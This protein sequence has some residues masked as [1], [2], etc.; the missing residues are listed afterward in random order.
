MWDCS[1]KTA[2][3]T[4]H[5]YGYELNCNSFCTHVYLYTTQ[6]C[7]FKMLHRQREKHF[8][9]HASNNLGQTTSKV[10]IPSANLTLTHWKVGWKWDISSYPPPGCISL[11]SKKC[12]A[13]L[14]CLNSLDCTN[15][16]NS[17]ASSKALIVYGRKCDDVRCSH[18]KQT[19]KG[20]TQEKGR[21]FQMQLDCVQTIISTWKKKK[22]HTPY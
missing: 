15:G 9:L 20:F 2:W 21:G 16:N 13:C 22:T 14:S 11:P 1:F 8:L 6:Y 4:N 7:V 18:P 12:F 10:F 17:A 3:A 19:F 5:G